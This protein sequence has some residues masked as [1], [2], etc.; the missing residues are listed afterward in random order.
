MRSPQWPLKTV[1]LGLLVVL[2][3]SGLLAFGGFGGDI[4]EETQR[5]RRLEMVERQIRDRGVTD[6]AVLA[7][8]SKVPRHR[9]VP[10]LRQGLAYSDGP[11]PIGAGQTISQPYIVAWM[12]ELIRPRKEMRVLEIG[13]GSGY[14]SA[15]LAE[16]VAE[17]DSIEV[18]PGLGRQAEARLREL[19]YRNVRVR[20]GDGYEGWP[21]R[22][23]YDAIILTAAPPKKVP[24]PLLDQLKHGGRLVAPV[25]RDFQRMVR[26]TR[27]ETGFK[28]ESLG[29][30]MF[31]PMTGKAQNDD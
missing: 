2:G 23:P 9:F 8:M 3:V 24:R 18:V 10:P 7:A 28:R 1:L 15:V 27:T 16:C 6:K 11:L 17:V 22:A 25:G 29:A 14:Q 5:A 4:P 12:T 13:T 20:I 26:F 21:D 19:D 31:V 30:V